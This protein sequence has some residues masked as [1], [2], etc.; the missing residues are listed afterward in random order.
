MN[1]NLAI[2][3]EQVASGEASPTVTT[4]EFL[5]WFNAQRRG[6]SIVRQ[7]RRELEL[8]NLVTVPDFESNYIDAPLHLLPTVPIPPLPGQDKA[9]KDTI[10]D[11]IE[12]QTDRTEAS[13]DWVRRD[14]TYRI[15]KLAPANQAIISVKPD[16]TLAEVVGIL[17]LKNFS[18]LPVMTNERDV[19]GVITWASIGSRLALSKPPGDAARNFMEPHHEIRSSFSIFDAIPIVVMHQYVLVRG[20]DNKVSGIIT[21]SDLSEQF[22]L[23]AEPFLLLGEIENLLRGLIADRFSSADLIE[24]R[25]PSDAREIQGPDDLAF[26]DYLRLLEKPERWAKF[27]LAI[28]RVS[29]CKD[30]DNIRRIRNDVMHFDSDGVLQKELDSLRDFKKFLNQIQSIISSNDSK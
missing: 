15:S 25:D 5:S 3:S 20:E 18:Q 16:S 28:D 27:G 6:Y 4:R 21:A 13:S 8:H 1:T 24:G 17:L 22:R 26:G 10:A 11:E 7:I 23:L 12:A 9:I 29:F 2:I 30:L 14:P 19:K